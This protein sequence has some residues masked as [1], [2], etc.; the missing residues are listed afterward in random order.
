M[1]FTRKFKKLFSLLALLLWIHL[2]AC[3]VYALVSQSPPQMPTVMLVPATTTQ[4]SSGKKSHATVFLGGKFYPIAISSPG[5]A[6]A[7]RLFDRDITTDYAPATPALV[8]V[9]FDSPQTIS[10]LRIY[11]PS[12]YALTVQ[13]RINGQWRNANAFTDVDLSS[14]EEQWRSY[15]C[16]LEAT[17]TLRLQLIPLVGAE[18][19]KGI[20]EIEFWSPGQHEHVRSGMELH[21]LLDQGVMVNQSRQYQ[22]E[23]ASGVIGPDEGTYTDAAN[24]NTFRFDLAYQPEQIKRAYLSYELSGLARWT[25]AIRSINEQTAMGG[26]VIERGGQPRWVAG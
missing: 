22:A 13:E 20:R 1:F 19:G 6:E 2:D 26:Y 10:E 3:T 4:T 24:D 12:S 9:R 7:T 23:P 11:G 21:S 8:E 14:Q 16:E 15:A 5:N 17:D 18:E 25:G